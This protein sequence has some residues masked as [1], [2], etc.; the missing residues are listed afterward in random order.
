MAEEDNEKDQL[1]Y[2][3][4]LPNLPPGVKEQEN[5]ANIGEKYELQFS[6]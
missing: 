2:P 4:P 5:S 3:Y 6:I 1:I